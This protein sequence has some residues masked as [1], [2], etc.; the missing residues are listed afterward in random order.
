MTEYTN[1]DRAGDQYIRRS[2][3]GFIFN[4]G[5]EAISWSCKRQP[6]VALST[7]KAEYTGQTQATKE[8]VWLKSVLNE[9]ER[10]I[11]IQD[12]RNITPPAPS[13]HS[14]HEVIINC[15]NQGTVAL[16]K[17]PQAYARSKQIDI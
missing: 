17:N 16:A 15:D 7:C 3:S 4:V 12:P 1:A 8:A 13:I 6:T 10:P 2:T 14:M 9:I 5:S 11:S